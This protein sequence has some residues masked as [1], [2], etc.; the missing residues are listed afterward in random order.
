M[1][2]IFYAAANVVKYSSPQGSLRIISQHNYFELLS[3]HFK[4]G[5]THSKFLE[6]HSKFFET[7]F[8]FTTNSEIFTTHF[9]IFAT[10]FEIFTTHSS[11]DPKCWQRKRN[12]YA[13][14]PFSFDA[15]FYVARVDNN[16]KKVLFF[17]QNVGWSL[18][19]MSPKE[20]ATLT[21]RKISSK[22][23]FWLV[24]STTPLLASLKGSTVF[25]FHCQH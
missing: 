14:R 23:T 6:T 11:Q 19:Q 16:Y 21:A 7:H 5:T 2:K 17:A 24:L 4:L 25:T 13:A 1:C 22:H 12:A 9:K 10:H 15:M 8:K 20:A 3:M 18:P